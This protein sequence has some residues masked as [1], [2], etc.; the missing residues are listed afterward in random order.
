[1]SI[2]S[3]ESQ[4]SVLCPVCRHTMIPATVN[5]PD[6]E[7]VGMC[8]CP[9]LITQH[10]NHTVDHLSACPQCWSPNIRHRSR[11]SVYSHCCSLF[12]QSQQVAFRLSKFSFN[13]FLL[14]FTLLISTVSYV[15]TN[16]NIWVSLLLVIDYNIA[17]TRVDILG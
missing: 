4:V 14:I 11:T 16:Q 7:T 17:S 9:A 3:N 6:C 13:H 2:L 12:H 10:I 1:M 8:S 15:S 5:R